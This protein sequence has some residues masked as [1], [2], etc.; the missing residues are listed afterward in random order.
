MSSPLDLDL[1]R[2][3]WAEA[4]NT[5]VYV[6][7]RIHGTSTAATPYETWYHRKP[8]VSHFRMFGTLAYVH[9]PK[10]LR[11]KLD[12]KS[13]PLL[14]VGY[15]ETHKAYRFFDR[16]TRRI[17]ISRDAIFC[18][19]KADVSPDIG[20]VSVISADNPNDSINPPQDIQH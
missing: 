7:N 18:E 6:N 10:C 5:A 20:T 2:D 3:L 4:V 14:F 15:S 11:K 13:R 9:I 12:A 1:P 16:V 8:D 19:L 17:T